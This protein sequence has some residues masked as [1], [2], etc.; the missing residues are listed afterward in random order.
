M[1]LVDEKAVDEAENP[2]DQRSSAAL[3]EGSKTLLHQGK[4]IDPKNAGAAADVAADAAEKERR[5][6]LTDEERAAEDK[7]KEE[8]SEQGPPKENETDGNEDVI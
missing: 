5:A 1:K 7:E 6:K 4:V 2:E 3:S 8:A